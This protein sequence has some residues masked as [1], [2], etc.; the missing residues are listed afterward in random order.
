MHT[1]LGEF[2]FKV[3]PSLLGRNVSFQFR[4]K[5]ER[6]KAT[7]SG[8]SWRQTILPKKE[9]DWPWSKLPEVKQISRQKF[10]YLGLPNIQHPT[11]PL[12]INPRFY[13]LGN[14]LLHL[15]RRLRCCWG[16]AQGMRPG[17]HFAQAG[18]GVWIYGP[19]SRSTTHTPT[20]TK[21]V[22]T[23]IISRQIIMTWSCD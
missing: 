23:T 15:P 19:F 7:V 8:Q 4:S 3:G 22:N 14:H 16:S 20:I 1:I 11:P 13:V 10:F 5:T 2:G 17:I 12:L 6:L 9:R 18:W 21:H